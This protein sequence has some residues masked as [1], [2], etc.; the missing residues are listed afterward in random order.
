MRIYLDCCCLQRPFDDQTQ[1]RIKVETEAVLAILASVQTGDVSLL[2]SEA[3][4]YEASRIPNDERRSQMAAILALANEYVEMT[5]GVEKLAESLEK[6]GI[7]PMDAI[8]L[9]L[10]STTGAD[11]FSTCDGKLLR[12]RHL[13]SKLECPVISLLDL[14]AEVLP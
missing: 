14:A 12:K 3:L 2:G 13:L 10:A 1:P 11:F 9:A 8:H 7:F 4:D 5:Q 6:E